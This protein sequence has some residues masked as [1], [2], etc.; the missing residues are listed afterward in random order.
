MIYLFFVFQ[1]KD[2]GIL[3]PVASIFVNCTNSY[4]KKEPEPE[5]VE[6]AKFAKQHVPEEHEKVFRLLFYFIFSL[7]L[8]I[9]FHIFERTGRSLYQLLTMV[10]A[11]GTRICIHPHVSHPLYHCATD[12]DSL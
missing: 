2:K 7:Y 9:S 5:L 1:I 11:G 12:A 10:G 8:I 4:D 3:Y 6:I